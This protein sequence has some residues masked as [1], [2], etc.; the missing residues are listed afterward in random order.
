MAST[1]LEV[2]KESPRKCRGS[3]RLTGPGGRQGFFL[4]GNGAG[5]GGG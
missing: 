1:E 3:F 4:G 2:R 5:W